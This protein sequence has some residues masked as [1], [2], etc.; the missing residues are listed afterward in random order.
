MRAHETKIAKNPMDSI[1]L[2]DFSLS[3]FNWVYAF[4][5]DE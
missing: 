1:A 2:P 3:T 5:K 4:D